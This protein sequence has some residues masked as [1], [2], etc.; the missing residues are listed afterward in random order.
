MTKEMTGYPS[1][2]KPWMKYYSEVDK[3]WNVPESK[4]Y[5]FIYEKNKDY[6]NDTALLYMG[7]SYTYGRVFE[8][9]DEAAKAF[10]SLGIG[11]GDKVAICSVTTPE[12][13][14]A[15]Y[16]LNKLGVTVNMLE[17]RNNAE[18]IKDYLIMSECEYMVMLD[19]CYPK[20]AA[21]LKD[22]GLKKVIVVSPTLSAAGLYKLGYHFTFKKSSRIPFGGVYEKWGEFIKRGSKIGNIK[23]AKYD[24]NRTAVIVY[25]G[26]TTGIPK[27]ARLSDNALNH[28]AEFARISTCIGK[29]RQEYFLG[30]MPPFI[31]YGLCCG[32]HGPLS[33]GNRLIVIP[34]F[35]PENFT[36]LVLKHKPNHFIGVPAFF[37][38]FASYEKKVDL[39]FVKAAIAGGDKMTVEVENKVNE[40]LKA[41]NAKTRIHKGYGMTE[42]SS[43]VVISI[44]E[45][46]KAGSVGIP[47]IGNSVKVISC[48][49]GQELK[50]GEQGEICIST[51]SVMLGYLNNEEET[52]KIVETDAMGTKWVHTGD[53]G[54]VDEDGCIFI[55]D[56]MKRMI[57]RPDGHNVFPSLIETIIAACEKVEKVA[58][59]GMFDTN[60][61]SGKW[62]VAH[63]V[64]KAEYKDRQEQV[65]DELIELMKRKL[66]ERDK[67][68]RIFFQEDLPL[69]PIGKVDYRRLEEMSK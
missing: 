11:E 1:I 6:L 43:G 32:I 4:M 58:V 46:N 55:L 41:N 49:S 42:M 59:V 56:R 37:E 13:I 66:P 10:Q 45:C 19:I 29:E 27:G 53:I 3:A 23:R 40:F 36:K 30:I 24:A 67:A 60:G 17:P 57:I 16:G 14:Y 33:V 5:D 34:N 62:P 2:D 52:N 44:D 47:L 20:I 18:R 38:E 61:L 51:P 39:S 68:E 50:Y 35:K 64:V 22:T 31:A 69:T 63:V 15:L 21:I 26:G 25:T 28:I 48:E 8:H 12:I 65:E 54:Y 7:K 9:I